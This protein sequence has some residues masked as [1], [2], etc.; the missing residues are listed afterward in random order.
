MFALTQWRLAQPLASADGND[1][2][3]FEVAVGD[4]ARSIV[5]RIN[6]RFNRD[7]SALDYRL[8]QFLVGV[9]RLP[10]GVYR[11]SPNDTWLSVWHRI[12]N[13]EEALFS[14]TLIE[15]QTIAQWMRQLNKAEYM[16]QTID[17]VDELPAAMGIEHA[18]PEGWFYPETYHYRAH[19][20]DRSIL[21]RAHDRMKS[22]VEESWQQRNSRCEVESPYELLILASI[23]E[24]ETG[25]AGERDLVSSVFHNR[26]RV[27]MRLQSDPTTIYG[28]DD[29]NGNLT[30]A[31]LREKTPY[32]TY[33][34]DGLPP[35][36]IAIPSEAAV[37]AAAQPVASN[38]FYFVANKQGEHVFSET[39][40]QHQRA[41][42]RYQLNQDTE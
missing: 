9:D 30:R 19:E 23:I 15:G 5:S 40:D 28:I 1:D 7:F 2:D 24:K 26:L 14:I 31:H 21:R 11:L 38:Y 3:V 33:R 29:F 17:R 39:L 8:S 34:I 42:R 20:T 10:A 25:L 36:P 22:I 16:K 13:N 27:G 32:N 6:S 35:T 41:V 12:K 37:R 18:S 4:T